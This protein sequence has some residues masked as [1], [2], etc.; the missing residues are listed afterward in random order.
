MKEGMKGGMTKGGRE[1]VNYHANEMDKAQNRMREF[2]RREGGYEGERE[3][4]M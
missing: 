1:H 3:G 2:A 4:G